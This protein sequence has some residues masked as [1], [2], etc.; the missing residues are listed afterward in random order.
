[1]K[2]LIYSSLF[3]ALAL[4]LS[5]CTSDLPNYVSF[6][7][8]EY[9]S[10][11][12][13]GGQWKP[14]LLT[15]ATQIG[16]PAPEAASSAEF[17]AEVAEVK[18]LS[19]SLTEEQQAA[20]EYWGSNS[21][22]R[23][24]EIARDLAAKY[25]L[26]AS[27]N[28]DGTYSGAD[29]ANPGNY[30]YFPFAHPPYASR[31]LAY[32]STA[33]F[34]A[35][36]AVWHY[37]N[38]YNR[39]TPA[40]ADASVVTHLPANALP[41]YPSDGATVAAV[42]KAILSA[43]FPLEKEYIAQKALE[44]QNA[45]KWAGVNVQSDIQAGDSLGRAVAAVFLARAG[46]DG[47]K[48]AQTPKAISDSIRD[49]AQARLGW[50]WENQESPVRPVGITPLF[51]KVKLWCVPNVVVVRP[52]PPP[53][54]GSAQF[55]ADAAELREFAKNPTPEQRKIANFWSDGLGT[56][57]PPGHWNRLASDYIVKYKFNPLR[58][59]RTFAYLNMAIM[60]AGISCWD[61]KYYY[62]YPRPI[63]TM[64]GFKTILG[65]PNFPAY[66]S[67][68]STFSA[69]AAEVLSYIFPQEQSYCE[70]WAEEASMSRVYA[71][72]HYRF[73]TEAGKT[74]GKAVAAYAVDKAKVDGAD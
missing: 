61:A 64:P 41:G 5:S 6:E 69:A 23:W 28:A 11:D 44:H 32:W 60:D 51:G 13:T 53:A 1:M 71:G 25:N 36:I 7:A 29:P 42:S 37:K 66:T 15:S 63:Q 30:P 72:I 21:L 24:N 58:S 26:P 50:H 17:L 18:T 34:D 4:L 52:V 57:T 54:P 31:A 45:L 9:A 10:L 14:I 46:S 38:Q 56:Y 55:E 65:T 49:D 35:L 68:H 16:I 22:I 74:Q 43:M 33:Q 39:P 3:L 8:Y 2:S 70:A 59:A 62:H 40:Q 67:G 27:P 48:K 47:M 12:A 19:A 20:V 73:D